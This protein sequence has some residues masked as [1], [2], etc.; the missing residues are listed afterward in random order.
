MPE[1][2]SL[3]EPQPESVIYDNEWLYVCLASYPITKGHVIVAW[4]NDL[5]DLRNLSDSE[6]D[7]FMEIMDVARDA[8]LQGL[9]VEKVY[10]LYMDE[11]KH[12][13][14]HL[15]PR[16]NE[17]GFNVFSHEPQKTEDFSL[18]PD[19]K[20]AFLERLESREI[21]LPK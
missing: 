7:Y 12:V 14:W 1:K 9:K 13:H 6:Y 16:Y 8:M 5:P 2:I 15:V 21:K 19:L 17:Q 10:L 18:A 20:K 11:A 4:K 3:P